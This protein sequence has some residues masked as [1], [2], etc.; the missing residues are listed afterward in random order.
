MWRFYVG[1]TGV[2]VRQTQVWFR[3]TIDLTNILRLDDDGRAVWKIFYEAHGS[4]PK[5][6]VWC[7]VEIEHYDHCFKCYHISCCAQ[8]KFH[9]HEVGGCCSGEVVELQFTDAYEEWGGYNDAPSRR[10]WT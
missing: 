9:L 4:L 7:N 5:Q 8:Q 10:S 1:D 2:L 6:E 3:A